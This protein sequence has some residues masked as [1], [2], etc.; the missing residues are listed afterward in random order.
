[1]HINFHETLW[2][3]IPH[4]QLKNAMLWNVDMAM[5]NNS[6]YCNVF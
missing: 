1:M 5:G 2:Q 3:I 4:E 6:I